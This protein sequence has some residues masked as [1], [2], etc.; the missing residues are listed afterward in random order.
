MKARR[1]LAA[2]RDVYE[3][4]GYLVVPGL[5]SGREVDLYRRHYHKLILRLLRDRGENGASAA[6]RPRRLDTVDSSSFFNL[7]LDDEVS[8]GLFLHPRIAA[9]LAWLAGKEHYGVMSALRLKPPMTDGLPYHYDNSYFRISPGGCL[10]TCLALDS[11]VR[12]TG[13]MAVVPESQ[14]DAPAVLKEIETGRNGSSRPAEKTRL[15]NIRMEPGDVL[16]LNGSLV[17][18]SFPNLS[19]RYRRTF[20][21]WY[22][23]ADARQMA[24]RYFP[25]LRLDGAEVRGWKARRV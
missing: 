10:T 12:R 18:M 14:A 21:A 16:F 2:L 15:R 4:E 20:F 13:C 9:F 17:H 19:R 5:F 3:R 24:R 1:P 8:R 11:C 25:A 23:P 22:A 6:A 7:H